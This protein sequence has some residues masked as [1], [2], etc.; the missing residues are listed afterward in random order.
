[1]EKAKFFL[2]KVYSVELN[3][4]FQRDGEGVQTKKHSVGGGGGYGRRP[5]SM[6]IFWNCAHITCN[7]VLKKK[8]EIRLL[9]H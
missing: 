3:W 7:P 2:R 8:K 6:D 1:M 5:M 4:N 9:Q